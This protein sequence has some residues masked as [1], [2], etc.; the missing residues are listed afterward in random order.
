M[1]NA[2][3]KL[4]LGHVASV[5]ST[6]FHASSPPN[7]SST[8]FFF[9][10]SFLLILRSIGNTYGQVGQK[11]RKL[12]LIYGCSICSKFPQVGQNS[13]AIL[14][15]F[16]N[17]GLQQDSAKQAPSLQISRRNI[18][19]RNSRAHSDNAL[20]VCSACLSIC[21]ILRYVVSSS[22]RRIHCFSMA[23]TVFHSQSSRTV[24]VFAL[25]FFSK[26]IKL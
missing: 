14:C 11:K 4:H 23:S 10:W 9:S 21:W 20:C 22:L 2:L 12:W 26:N 5:R 1:K 17:I 18:R 19:L 3:P 15:A 16:Q 24:D 25:L 6:F 13:M 8:S 7:T